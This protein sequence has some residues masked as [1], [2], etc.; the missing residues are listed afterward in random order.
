LFY[1]KTKKE[2]SN[3]LLDW[4]NMGLGGCDR[5]WLKN[6]LGIYFGILLNYICV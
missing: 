5:P 3:E 2:K 4:T 1:G 6:Y